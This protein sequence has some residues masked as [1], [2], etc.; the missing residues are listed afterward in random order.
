MFNNC[1]SLSRFYIPR[2]VT[3]IY[4][5]PF[6]NCVGLEYIDMTDYSADGKFPS[7]T[8]GLGANI[9]KYNKKGTF[10]IRVPAGRKAELAAKT[11]WAQYADNIVEV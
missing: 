6:N 9:G 8:S 1:V 10:E 11:N 2:T 7:L 4:S 3:Q 5:S